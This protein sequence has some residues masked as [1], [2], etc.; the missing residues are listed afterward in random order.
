[1]FLYQ[2]QFGIA[3]YAPATRFS[4]IPSGLEWPGPTVVP[5]TL[6]DSAE[7]ATSSARRRSVGNEEDRRAIISINKLRLR[8]QATLARLF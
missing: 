4:L 5:V 2:S 1:M 3:L 8:V 6:Y 7:G